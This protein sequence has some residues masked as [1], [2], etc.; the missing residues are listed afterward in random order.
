M[1]PTASTADHKQPTAADDAR[2]RVFLDD[3]FDAT[4]DDWWLD[5]GRVDLPGFPGV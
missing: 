3:A 1:T 2:P 5:L 4:A